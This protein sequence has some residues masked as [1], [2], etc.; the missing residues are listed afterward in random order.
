MALK[1]GSGNL[2]DALVLINK[3]LQIRA[4]DPDYLD[5]R[6]VVY[7]SAGQG[8]RRQGPR[9]GRCRAAHGVQVIPPVAGVS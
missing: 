5:T 4:A 8:Q 3:A 2:S 1:G 9:S 7:L 6:G